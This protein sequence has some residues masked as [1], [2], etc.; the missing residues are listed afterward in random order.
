MENRA[1][2]FIN[3]SSLN[4]LVLYTRKHV[5]VHGQVKGLKVKIHR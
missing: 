4:K 2:G 1:I 3:K 5:L